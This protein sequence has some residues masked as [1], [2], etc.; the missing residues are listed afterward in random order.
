MK[1]IQAWLASKKPVFLIGIIFGVALHSLIG[2]QVCSE[3]S[4]LM[5]TKGKYTALGNCRWDMGSTIDTGEF[6]TINEG[7]NHDAE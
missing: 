2:Y 4:E 3:M 6:P 5:N 1:K 7:K